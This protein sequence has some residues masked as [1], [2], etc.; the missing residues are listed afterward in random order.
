M[1]MHAMDRDE[2]AA[3][4]YSEMETLEQELLDLAGSHGWTVTRDGKSTVSE[5][6]YYDVTAKEASAADEDGDRWDVRIRVRLAAHDAR[7]GGHDV[8]VLIP[9]ARHSYS[10]GID[11][12]AEVMAEAIDNAN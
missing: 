12:V 11:V 5:S 6:R 3:L 9:S 7:H 10:R 1:N 4:I 8:G 2:R